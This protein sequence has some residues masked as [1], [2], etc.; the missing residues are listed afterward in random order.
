MRKLRAW[1]SEVVSPK[2]VLLTIHPTSP[3]HILIASCIKTDV[4]AADMSPTALGEIANSNHCNN[5]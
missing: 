4:I 1:A 2:S 3:L 5:K